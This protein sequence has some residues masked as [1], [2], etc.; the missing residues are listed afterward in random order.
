[1]R[2]E[3]ECAEFKVNNSDEDE[4][5]EY[6][7]ALS[8]SAALI[9]EPTAFIVWGVNDVS[10]EVVGT[11][12]KPH[13][14]KI[15]KEALENWLVTLLY[16]RINFKIHEVEIED[17]PVV[18]FEVPAAREAPVRFRETEYIRVGSAKTK[19][20]DYPQRERTLWQ[21]LSGYRF[22]QDI[23][24]PDVDEDTTLSLLDYPAYFDVFSQ[25][26]PPDRDA[27]LRRFMDEK[28]VLHG[29][30]GGF[31]IT[32]LGA[33]LFAKDLEQFKRLSRKT[34]R[35]IIYKGKNR[36]ETQREQSESKG[37]AC[38]F[39]RTISNINNQLPMSEQVGQ[40]LRKAVPMYPEIAVRELVANAL[41]HQ[42]FSITGAGPTVEVFEDRVEITNPGEPLIQTTR[43]IDKPPRSRNED[44][45]KFMRRI[46]IVEER[47]SGIDKV[48]SAIEESQLPP[49]DFRVKDDNTIAI[50]YAARPL[51]RMTGEERIRACY[52]HACLRYVSNERMTNASL[53]QR[54]AIADKNYSI[55]S[56][57]IAETLKA[58]LIKPF[59]SENTS[60]KH[61]SYVPFW[62]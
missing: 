45:A 29:V 23:A 40:A 25:P 18:V 27:I 16:P 32:N 30:H 7:S 10:H 47:G 41:V 33:I 60:K 56:R 52:Q 55:A 59:D 5:G 22:E 35:V 6:I 58:E 49:P 37:Y 9:K 44:L 13:A 50:L 39:T 3:H 21:L 8:N 51:T 12:F 2:R 19:L 57:I 54:F 36:V 24:M 26:L 43:F 4:I 46:N 53:R 48:I 38:G 14:T 17:K 61:A 1:M 34:L 62:A 28:I 42:D 20:K 31:D 15:G 11:S